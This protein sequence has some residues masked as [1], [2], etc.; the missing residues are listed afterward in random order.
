MAKEATIIAL[1]EALEAITNEKRE[2]H[3]EDKNNMRTDSGERMGK[4]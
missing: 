1:T 4:K 2:Q 3:K